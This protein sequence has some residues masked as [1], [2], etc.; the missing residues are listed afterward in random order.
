MSKRDDVIR[1]LKCSVCPT[2]LCGNCTY[3]VP[4]ENDPDTGWCDR[5]AIYRDALELLKEQGPRLLKS[6]DFVEAD[7]WGSIP[8]WFEHNPSLG[9][10]TIDGWGLVKRENLQDKTTRYWTSRPT[11]EQKKATP[12]EPPKED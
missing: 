3:F 10:K 8:A 6:D 12:W 9:I 4:N 11:D 7:G 5:D 1:G 2:M